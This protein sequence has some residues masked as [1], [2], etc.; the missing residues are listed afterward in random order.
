[1]ATS[2]DSAVVVVVLIVVVVAVMVVVVVVIEVVLVQVGNE[3]VYPSVNL[4]G[5][6]SVALEDNTGLPV[7]N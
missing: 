5:R 4:R 3:Q 6:R 7:Y 1:M 2:D